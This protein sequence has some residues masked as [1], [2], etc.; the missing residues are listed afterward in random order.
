[1]V[2]ENYVKQL[3]ANIEKLEDEK[4][5]IRVELNKH[6]DHFGEIPEPVPDLTSDILGGIQTTGQQVVDW[7]DTGDIYFNHGSLRY[8]IASQAAYTVDDQIKEEI[9]KIVN[10][11][12]DERETNEQ[13]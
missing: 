13:A 7:V 12:I 3:E 6:I 2:D 9:K 4:E 1:M 10:E 8:Q 11:T 5:E